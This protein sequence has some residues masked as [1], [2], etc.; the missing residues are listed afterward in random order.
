MTTPDN[1][2]GDRSRD[3][4]LAGEYVLGV[5][6]ICRTAN[7]GEAHARRSRFAAIVHRWQDNLS[8][9]NDDYHDNDAA[10]SRSMPPIEKQLF[11]AR[12][13]RQPGAAF[14][15]LWNSVA[16]WRGLALVALVRPALLFAFNCR[17]LLQA[18]REHHRLWPS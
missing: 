12:A 7:V 10:A 3:E 18:K 8:P 13:P 11:G 1:K 6:P 16:F 15:R 14:Q 9:F 4:V 5:L 2:K 17:P